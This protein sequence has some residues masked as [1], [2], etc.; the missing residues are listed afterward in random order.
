LI[1]DVVK[2][3]E[4]IREEAR[5]EAETILAVAVEEIKAWEAEKTALAKV[6]Q[7]EPM[8]KLDVGGV[9]YTASLQTLCRFPDTMLECMFSGRHTLLQGEDGYFFIDRDGTHF[10]HILNFLAS[11]RATEW[12]F[13]VQTN[14]SCDARASTTASTS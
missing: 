8:V 12:R 7:F 3:Y 2:E 11:Q 13:R 5:I 10:R 1:T 9:C 4:K 14:R 6:Q